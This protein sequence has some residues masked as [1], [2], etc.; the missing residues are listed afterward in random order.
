MGKTGF[1]LSANRTKTSVSPIPGAACPD[2]NEGKARK[3]ASPKS[4]IEHRVIAPGYTFSLEGRRYQLARNQ[5]HPLMLYQS[6][7]LEIGPGDKLKVRYQG[8][9]VECAERQKPR[10]QKGYERRKAPNAGGKSTWAHNF[11]LAPGPPVWLS[12]ERAV[13]GAISR[14]RAELAE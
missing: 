3:P 11:L 2:Q 6:L 5:V 13:S 7:Q 10:Y 9:D 12:T 1:I 14:K 8:R 4:R